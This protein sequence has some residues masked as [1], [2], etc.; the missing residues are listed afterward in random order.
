MADTFAHYL[1]AGALFR[2]TAEYLQEWIE[3]HLLVGVERFSLYNNNSADNFE[4]VLAPYVEAGVV[5]ILDWPRP[6]PQW[7]T[8]AIDDCVA[9]RREDS[10]WLT[11]LNIDQFLFSPT[12]RPLPEVLEPFERWAGVAVNWRVFGTSGHVEKPPGLVIESYTRR[13]DDRAPVMK[14]VNTIV[15]PSRALRAETPH[16]FSYREGGAVDEEQR[17]LDGLLTECHS[18]RL[19]R[20][21]HYVTR[22][23]AE[24][25]RKHDLWATAVPPRD[26]TR[27]WEQVE[28]VVSR[29]NSTFDDAI[30]TYVPALKAA[31]R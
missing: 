12:G 9:R 24:L 15:D 7:E 19:L 22:S 1:S 20:I 28:R 11:F 26:D 10:R 30:T 13:A 8:R 14:M 25:R 5:E 2:D 31:L 17:P 23:F 18:S 27:P 4:E 3:F 6:F 16:N 29:Y 21:N